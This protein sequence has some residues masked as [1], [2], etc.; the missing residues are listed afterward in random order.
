MRVRVRVFVLW[1]VRLTPCGGGLPPRQHAWLFSLYVCGYHHLEV[2]ELLLVAR[3]RL[4]G[5]ERG[6][7]LV[8]R[9]RTTQDQ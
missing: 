2:L 7:G 3:E 5:L 1:T 6:D 8:I 9:L 4:D